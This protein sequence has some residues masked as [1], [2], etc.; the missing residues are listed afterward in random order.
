MAKRKK[1]EM[2]LY[3]DGRQEKIP[4]KKIIRKD[5]Q[6]SAGPALTVPGRFH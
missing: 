4:L 1:T 3:K 6:I 5:E 2:N